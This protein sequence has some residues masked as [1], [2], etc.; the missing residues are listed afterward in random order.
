M[1]KM[2]SD[3]ISRYRIE[4][5]LGYEGQSEVFKA[6]DE[7]LKRWVAIKSILP[8][9]EL[10]TREL[11]RAR[12]EARAAAAIS[13]SAVAQVH[14][15]F[16]EDGQ[17]H[18]VMEFVEGESLADLLQRGPLKLAKALCLGLD[19]ANGLYAAHSQGVI[20]RDLKVD[21][22]M[23]TSAGRAKILDFGLAKLSGEDSGSGSHSQSDLIGTIIAMS[24]EQI[25]Q[26]GNVDHRSDLFSF[27]TMLYELAT[28][29]HPFRVRLPWDTITNIVERD[30]V[31]PHEVNPKVPHDVSAM[32]MQLLAKDQKDR[33]KG[34]DVIRT[35][36][37]HCPS[38]VENDESPRRYRLLPATL[39]GLGL[40]LAVAAGVWLT[41]LRNPAEPLFVV[42]LKPEVDSS[43][44]ETLVAEGVYMATINTLTS[45][46]AVYPVENDGYQGDASEVAR[47]LKVDEAVVAQVTR[48][49][50]DLM[51]YQV[52]V[53][54]VD[55]VDGKLL[56]S[57]EFAV[58]VDDLRS[59]S[60]AVTT[61]VR[62]VYDER[63]AKDDS[64]LAQASTAD[65]RSY[66]DV[67]RQ[68]YDPDQPTP[69]HE[70]LDRLRKIRESSPGLLDAYALEVTVSL[71]AY[72]EEHDRGAL[73]QAEEAMSRFKQ[74]A[75]DDPRTLLTETELALAL[76]DLERAQQAI[77]VMEAVAPVDPV[78]IMLKA[79]LHEQQGHPEQ[80]IALAEESVRR[81]PS[82]RQLRELAAMEMRLGKVNAAR[83]HLQEG[84]RRAPDNQKLLGQ[85]A[86]LELYHG[87]PEQAE[88]L[89][90]D[91]ATR[92]PGPHTIAGLAMTKNLLGKAEEASEHLEHL[93]SG[94]IRLPS[95][96][97]TLSESYRLQG[98]RDRADQVCRQLLDQIESSPIETQVSDLRCQAQ[99]LAYIGRRDEAEAVV[100]EV[101]RLAPDSPL[102]H[103]SAAIVYELTGRD[104]NAASNAAKALEL[105]LSQ[106]WLSSRAARQ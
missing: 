64:Y 44:P 96:L 21:N 1:D 72:L 63:E 29:V 32:I 69:T 43:I 87:S 6:W 12:R 47:T 9:G 15:V 22:I 62:S 4:K 28:G 93:V 76:N 45:L 89:Y 83:S 53:R 51:E 99:C 11:K 19:V 85:L 30:P 77:E 52:M 80:A 36:E 39:A 60:D 88:S 65:Y 18:M 81:R 79:K 61:Y 58:P 100:T 101:L 57:V 17:D 7:E 73:A 102:A 27:G 86:E 92:A 105:G 31:P 78:H 70:L 40:V 75:P 42:V 35:L 33:P 13:H 25:K 106:S 94:G 66:L 97:L 98:E 103:Y 104:D 46:E 95:T 20:H 10:T 5:R 68:F 59:L 16:T 37:R 49:P 67:L 56:Q 41:H 8:A 82:A 26:R 3:S 48:G 38:R 24:P 55:A 54:R 74:L 84:L 14:D 91:L 50:T 34:I 71:Q 90:R 23:V 2:S